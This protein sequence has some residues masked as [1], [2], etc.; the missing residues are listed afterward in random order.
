[1]RRFPI[2]FV[3]L[4]GVVISYRIIVLFVLAIV[5]AIVML[6]FILRLYRTMR[7]AVVNR[8]LTHVDNMDGIQFE[9]YIENVLK[10]CGYKNIKLTEKYDYGV[11][12]IAVKDGIR[13]GIQVKRHS[14]LVKADAVRQ[15]VT[16][17]LVYGC[18]RAM[19]ITNSVFSRAAVRLAD[20]NECVLIDRRG[21]LRIVALNWFGIFC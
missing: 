12:I 18:D 2:F 6:R 4:A 3:I 1:M 8:R 16:G 14:G 15:V 19:V 11:D 9:S 17:L 13:W 5:L 10:N 21:L 7:N 20:S